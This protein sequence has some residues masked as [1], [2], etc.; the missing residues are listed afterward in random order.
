MMRERGQTG[1]SR[2][3]IDVRR[4]EELSMN[5]WPALR[6]MAHDGWVLRFGGGYTGRSNSVH[7][8][9][10]GALDVHGK[11]E[12]CE[13]AYRRAGIRLLFKMTPAARPGELDDLL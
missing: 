8:L 6:R 1:D 11:I 2:L 10:D 13:R 12:F 4:M 7:P 5:A 9:Y 3:G